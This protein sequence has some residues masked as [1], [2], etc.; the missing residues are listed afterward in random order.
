MCL[1][2]LRTFSLLEQGQNFQVDFYKVGE[3]GG[4]TL[5]L[6]V[7]GL[8]CSPPA[9]AGVQCGAY[10]GNGSGF[11]AAMQ[12]HSCYGLAW[13]SA[14]VVWETNEKMMQMAFIYSN[15]NILSLSTVSMVTMPSYSLPE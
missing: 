7:G 2:K 5:L 8:L 15:E 11:L 10:S 3:E 1:G 6:T 12:H 14:L 9:G 13:E 4:H